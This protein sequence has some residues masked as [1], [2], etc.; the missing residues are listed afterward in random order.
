ME[1]GPKAQCMQLVLSADG[2]SA[3]TDQALPYP[4]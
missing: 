1:L 3:M 4:R 2:L